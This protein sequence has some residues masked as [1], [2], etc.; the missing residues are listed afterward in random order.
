MNCE[1]MS[2]KPLS[3][4]EAPWSPKPPNLLYE[5]YSQTIQPYSL[6]IGVGTGGAIGVGTGG[7]IRV[8]TGGGIGEK[9]VPQ[10][11]SRFPD[12]RVSSPATT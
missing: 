1:S 10:P 2:C 4:T 3:P 8:G 9:E 7:A 5:G 6:A 11:E 12:R